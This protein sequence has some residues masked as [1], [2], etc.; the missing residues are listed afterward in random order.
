[1]SAINK[2][3]V[4][5]VSYNIE[6]SRVD[7]IADSIPTASTEQK[8]LVQVG[9]GINVDENGVISVEGGSGS[10]D[11]VSYTDGGTPAAAV[12]GT[13]NINGT[14]YEIKAP[15]MQYQ[16]N[17]GDRD[18]HTVL[19]I[20]DNGFGSQFDINAPA[21]SY[22]DYEQGTN[23]LGIINVGGDQYPITYTPAASGDSVQFNSLLA[24]GTQ[25][26]TITING[27]DTAIYAPAGGSGGGSSVSYQDLTSPSDPRVAVGMITI[28][29]AGYNIYV[30]TTVA[31]DWNDITGKPTIPT[32]TS[33][34]TN[35]SGFVVD[36][37]VR[38]IAADEISNTSI[39]DLQNVPAV[40]GDVSGIGISKD[41]T[42]GTKIATI[43]WTDSSGVNSED[44]YAPAGGGSSVEPHFECDIA[45]DDSS[46]A[47]V[48][49]NLEYVGPA[50]SEESLI[51]WIGNTNIQ[52]ALRNLAVIKYQNQSDEECQAS[53]VCRIR[54]NNTLIIDLPQPLYLPMGE[55]GTS[56]KLGMIFSQINWTEIVTDEWDV[57]FEA[58][59]MTGTSFAKVDPILEAGTPIAYVNVETEED[60]TPVT[61]YAPNPGDTVSVTQTLASGTKIG[62]IDVNGTT[63]E[64]FA[65]QGG[66]GGDT[67]T[68]TPTIYSGTK[69]ADID[70]SGN[71]THLYTPNSV[72]S[73]SVTPDLSSGTKIAT[74]A[75]RDSTTNNSMSIYAPAGGSAG[76]VDWSDVQN[77][78]AIQ[79]GTPEGSYPHTANYAIQQQGNTANGD[80][81]IAIGYDTRATN[82]CAVAVGGSTRASGMWA[83]AT[84]DGTIASSNRQIAMG[85]YNTED[86]NEY[87]AVMVGNGSVS[88]GRKNAEATAWDGN[89]YIAGNLYVGCTDWTTRLGTGDAQ[90]VTPHAGGKKVLTEDDTVTVTQTLTTGTKI[91]EI[92]V[93]GTTTD[94]YAPAGGSS[95]VDW[96]D[97]T[98]KPDITPVAGRDGY[99]NIAG[100][101][102][103]VNQYSGVNPKGT[104]VIGNNCRSAADFALV[105]GQSSEVTGSHGV[106][107]GYG[108]EAGP[109]SIGLQGKAIRGNA[110]ALGNTTAASQYQ[111]T[112]GFNNILDYNG[113][114]GLIIGNG[115]TA[116]G[117]ILPPSDAM[118]IGFDGTQYLAGDL[119]VNCTDFTTTDV[120]GGEL[121]TTNCG[122][123]KVLTIADVAVTPVL[124]TGTHIANITVNGTTS[125]IY[126]P[127]LVNANWKE[128]DLSSAAYIQNKPNINAGTGDFSVRANNAVA[129]G[130]YAFA[131]N[132]GTARGNYSHAEGR[133]STGNTAECAH[134]EG[135]ACYAGKNYS[136]A[137][138][139]Y[140]QVTSNGYGFGGHAE[141]FY[142]RVNSQ[143]QHAQG[144]SNILD[145]NGVFADII[146][147]GSWDGSTRSNAEATDWNGNKYLSG[148][149]Y[150]GCTDYT[151]TA[152]G[153]TTLGAG[154]FRIDQAP[155]SICPDP[156][157]EYDGDGA[158]ERVV[159]VFADQVTK[160][161]EWNYDPETGDPT[162]YSISTSHDRVW[163]PL[164]NAE[165]ELKEF[166]VESGLNTGSYNTGFDSAGVNGIWQLQA[167]ISQIKDPNDSTQLIPDVDNPI[168][169]WK[170]V[171]ADTS[172]WD[173]TPDE[174]EEPEPDPENPEEEPTE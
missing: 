104:I 159:G 157:S 46:N 58:Q 111:T 53:G 65:P 152:N 118:A 28:D 139:Y 78:P 128:S 82:H 98:N 167:V 67:V 55:S 8:G 143:G 171:S 54:D 127:T 35:D 88:G 114:F 25:I 123:T 165:K 141:G 138:G 156:V 120:G 140:S 163:V 47:W 113:Q 106:A 85:T 166:E 17:I 61:L 71:T 39:Y 10:G 74:I 96:V 9:Q 102:G 73:M 89:K 22:T 32:A 69:I 18:S 101:G 133:S 42:S 108:A 63:T 164:P 117:G 83:V 93:G 170:F 135:D 29:G 154:G 14:D 45:Y 11:S 134:A 44:L 4:D 84:G 126:A 155:D 64:L 91:A 137:E 37:D 150:V 112:L 95:S 57:S 26:G 75:W 41:V 148:G 116:S 121:N 24:S 70:V 153:L 36:G 38:D 129:Q 80:Y 34:L 66:S 79:P 125:G 144:R 100:L 124:S 109:S 86:S 151:T 49:N 7:N 119:Y 168:F 2:I 161:A 62:E 72:T 92:D 1:M 31:V 50:V 99:N 19:G 147:N 21:V 77:K 174:P 146:G 158:H 136:H 97:I 6:D 30:P 172:A 52:T 60:G 131:E 115:I 160:Y 5:N 3:N 162:D 23:A 33:Q 59:C 27:V 90:L 142:T 15:W 145:S 43:S 48:V 130:A 40:I 20:I 12:I 132:G 16:D 81:S 56:Y 13:L 94:I 105:F 87:F 107:L 68:V 103:S 169:M 122:G 76:T 51:D 149:I 110:A 173:E